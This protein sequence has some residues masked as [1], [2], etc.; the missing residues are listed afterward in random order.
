MTHKWLKWM[1][2]SPKFDVNY[3][4][5]DLFLLAAWP[6]KRALLAA[7]PACSKGFIGFCMGLPI[8]N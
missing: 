7:T 5:N 1:S 8:C 3:I 2:Y 6:N 4:E